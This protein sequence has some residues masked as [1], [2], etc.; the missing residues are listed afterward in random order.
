MT[1]DRRRLLQAGGITALSAALPEL[2]QAQ[3]SLSPQGAADHTIRIG[4]GLVELAPDRII[5]TTTYNGQFPGPL[6]RFKEG[7]QVVVDIHNDTDTPEQLHWHG[8]TIPVDVDGASEEGTPFVPAHAMRASLAKGMPHGFEVGYSLFS[9]NGRILGHGDPIRVKAGERVLFHIVNGSAT[10]IRSLAL[11]GH[12][13]DVIAL[14]GNPVPTPARAPVLWLGTAER[15]SAI[16]EM[17]HPGVWVMG[18][19]ADDDRT[20]GMGIVIEYAGKT[21]KPKWT[22]P[23]PYKWD[24]THFGKSDADGPAPDETIEMMFTKKNAANQGFN[25]WRINDMAFSMDKMEPMF[26]LRQGKRYRLRMRN[27]SDDIHPVH[28]HRHSFE[29]TRIA[30]KATAGIMKDVV[31]LGGYQEVEVDFVADNPG[32]TLFHCHRQLHMDFG[33]MALF[34]YV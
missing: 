25:E 21:G 16:V 34:D 12:S 2:V 15:I 7:Q 10:E 1:M 31:M 29:L 13:F 14:D 24:Y 19:L 8:Q 17:N 27:A 33:F 28:L 32:L 3:A 22:K 11:P 20:R 23:A 6:L 26:H 30:G 18:D 5:S 9:I 4:N